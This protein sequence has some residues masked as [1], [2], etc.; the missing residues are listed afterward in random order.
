MLEAKVVDRSDVKYLDAEI[1][2][3]AGRVRASPASTFRG[4]DSLHLLQWCT[5]RGRYGLPTA[6]LVD[7]LRER[8]DGRKAIEVGAGMGDLGYHLGITMTDSC[9][10]QKHK[11]NK[12][13]FGQFVRAMYSMSRSTETKPPPDVLRMDAETAVRKLKPAVVV[14][15][16]LTQKYRNGDPPDFGASVWGADENYILQNCALYIFIGNE[17]T[18]RDKRILAKP[19]ETHKPD[20]L[21]SRALRPEQNVIWIWEGAKNR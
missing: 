15:S 5:E 12:T 9:I 6:E 2:N 13:Q 16:W 10:Q 3:E 8:I 17:H 14:A 18:H 20:W 21:V 19:H 11:Q 1:L 4:Y 7:F